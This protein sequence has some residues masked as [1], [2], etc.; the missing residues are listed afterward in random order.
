MPLIRFTGSRA[1]TTAASQGRPL[2]EACGWGVGRKGL[3]NVLYSGIV[4]DGFWGALET[5]KIR[6]QMFSVKFGDFCPTYGV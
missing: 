5:E 6:A 2:A 4:E 1:A 3:L